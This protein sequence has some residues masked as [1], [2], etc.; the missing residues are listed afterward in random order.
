MLDSAAVGSVISMISAE[1]IRK[2][3]VPDYPIYEQQKIANE[4]KEVTMTLRERAAHYK[5][6]ME[7]LRNKATHICEEWNADSTE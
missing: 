6:I 1:A 3:P 4:M 7:R 5:K 2:L